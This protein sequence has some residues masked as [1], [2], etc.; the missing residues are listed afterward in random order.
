MDIITVAGCVLLD[1]YGRILLLHR[2][3]TDSGLWYLPGG[4]VEEEELPESAAVRESREELGVDV[5]LRHLLASEAFEHEETEY[6]FYW[7]LAEIVE[8]EPTITQPELFDD[9]DYIEFE[10]M[11]SL[12]LSAASEILHHKILSGEVDLA[13]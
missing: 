5:R 7:F 11:P 8:G 1:D 9:L 10:D 3:L 2:K 4:K 13:F 6:L 12:A